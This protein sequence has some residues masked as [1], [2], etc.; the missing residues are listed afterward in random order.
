MEIKNE[1]L[2]RVYFIFFGLVLPFAILLVQ[3]C[4]VVKSLNVTLELPSDRL[5]ANCAPL[6][7]DP[8]FTRVLSSILGRG[9][10]RRLGANCS[11]SCGS[12]PI[13]KT[14]PDGNER[15]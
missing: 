12:G 10:G 7:P 13:A 15:A 14:S 11:D 8:G 3:C 6:V 9:S 2:Y 1:V 4:E 5:G